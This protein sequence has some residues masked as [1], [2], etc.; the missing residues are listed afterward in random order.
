MSECKIFA[1]AATARLLSGLFLMLLMSTAL[2]FAGC[3]S[4]TYGRLENSPEVTQVFKEGKILSNHQY[5][6]SGFQRVPYAIIAIADNYQLQ[7]GRWQPLDI[8]STTLDQMVYRMDH[9]YSLIPRGA[10]ILDHEGHRLGV[11]F[12]S[13]YQTTVQREKNNQ[14]MVAS[15]EPP[16]LRGVP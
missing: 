4:V 10:W 9:V 13:Q 5:Y 11:W 6:V 3:G 12:S 7:S 8:N 16:D 1:S 14:I 2:V 15:P